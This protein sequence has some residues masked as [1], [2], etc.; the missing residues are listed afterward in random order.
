M[1]I[2]ESCQ[3]GRV[4]RLSTGGLFVVIAAAG[5]TC[6]GCAPAADGTAQST[7]EPEVVSSAEIPSAAPARPDASEQPSILSGVDVAVETAERLDAAIEDA[8]LAGFVPGAMVGIWSPNGQYLKAFGLADK[9]TQLEMD[10][11]MFMRIGSITK[12]FTATAVL[13]LADEGKIALDDPIGMHLSG[14][15]NGDSITIRQLTGMRSGLPNY[16]DSSAWQ[17]K[18]LDDPRAGWTPEQLLAYAFSEPTLFEPDAMFHYSNTNY[19]LLGQLVEDVSGTPLPKFFG[20]RIFSP[21][22]MTSTVFPTDAVFPM[23]H[24]QGYTNVGGGVSAVEATDWNPS[25]GWA[26]G[27]MISTVR[28]LGLWAREAVTGTLISP[29]MQKERLGFMPAE[30]WGPDFRYGLG[31][32]D[33]NGWIGHDGSMPGYQGVAVHNTAANTSMV[34][35]INTDDAVSQGMELYMPY[36]L[37]AKAIT[38]VITPNHVFLPSPL[39]GG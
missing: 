29:E 11:S 20:D 38:D 19:I 16:A 8:R 30:E 1:T 27:A 17:E 34:I 10:P 31:L 15:P 32:I 2:T 21:L 23:P 26:A 4:R 12:T 25:W 5:L 22:G 28:D 13:Q 14:V 18:F 33:H 35:L 37:I 24:A 9:E 39:S 7:G 6:G 3:G 36:H